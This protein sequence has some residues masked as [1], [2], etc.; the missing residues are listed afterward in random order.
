M[1]PLQKDLEERATKQGASW[2][3]EPRMLC[4]GSLSVTAFQ[5]MLNAESASRL[6]QALR[7]WCCLASALGD[8]R[9]TRGLQ[10]RQ[11]LC[12]SQ[13]VP[14]PLATEP[15]PDSRALRSCPLR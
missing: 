12:A 3:E 7:G 6:W 9:V 4:V 8:C 14:A 1:C 5:V 11:A 10:H 13:Q 2:E 15:T